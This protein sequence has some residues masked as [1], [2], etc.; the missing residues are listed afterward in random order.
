MIAEIPGELAAWIEAATGGR[1]VCAK[2]AGE[3]ASRQAWAVDLAGP[4]GDEA[5]FCLRDAAGGSGGSMKD[6]AILGALATTEIPV[7]R[8]RAAS[9]ELSALLLER[10]P[11]RSDFPAVDLES[12]REPTA[13][14]LMRLTARLHALDP[15]TLDI[16]HLGRPAAGADPARAQLA[17]LAGLLATLGDDALPLQRFAATWLERRPPRAE[18]TSLVHSDMGPG[19]FL[20]QGG[21]VTGLL[22]WEVAHWGD[23]ME[24]LAAIAVRDMATPIGPLAVR[25]A[26]YAAAGGPKPDL[27]SIAWYRVFILARNTTLIALGLRRALEPASRA[28]LER[29]QLLLLRALA[30]CLCDVVGI[31][32]PEADP[33]EEAAPSEPPRRTPSRLLHPTRPRRTRRTPTTP[34]SSAASPST[35]TRA[36]GRMRTA[37]ANSSTAFRRG[38][39]QHDHG[40]R[41]PARRLVCR[42]RFPPPDL[43]RS[44]LARDRLVSVLDSGGGHQ[45]LRPHLVP[46]QRR[47]AGRGGPRLARHLAD[48]RLR[49][50][51][52]ALRRLRRPA[53]SRAPER[54]PARL[55]RAAH[56]LPRPPREPRP[57]RRR[58]LHGAHGAQSRSARGVARHVRGPPRAARA[59]RRERSA[60][61]HDA[62]RSIAAACATAPGGRARRGATCASATPTA[63][64]A[65]A[66]PSSST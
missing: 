4:A 37:S 55:P 39:S 24:D 43:R 41:S 46:T 8:V 21:R 42:R 38:S 64:R 27:A 33:A 18:R 23:P 57:R 51:D 59:R 36:P 63:P 34:R 7:P 15:A 62:S 58:R 56:A 65:R 16:P 5:L 60:S 6:A 22:D 19:N 17:Q 48:P 13:R 32:R 30:L 44:P 50:L 25:Y 53:R 9:P 40:H 49:R 29:F 14:D 45:R 10:L 47:R 54:L 1:I 28:P 20:Y 2:R 52:R 11:G 35:C 66:K 61:A 31:S 26:E 3:G 12:E